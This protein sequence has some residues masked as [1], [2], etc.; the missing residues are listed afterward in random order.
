MFRAQRRSYPSCSQPTFVEPTTW[1][2]STYSCT[3][4]SYQL[5]L[6][7]LSSTSTFSNSPNFKKSIFCSYSDTCL[8]R[9]SS[10]NSIIFRYIPVS[11]Y[12]RFPTF[13]IPVVQRFEQPSW[14]NVIALAIWKSEIHITPL[15]PSKQNI[16]RKNAYLTIGRNSNQSQFI[17]SSFLIK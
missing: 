14:S 11:I 15:Q 2:L 6:S 17:M 7:Q 1:S 9:L 12:R 13:N 3:Q 10:K 5:I 16:N 4:S 8:I